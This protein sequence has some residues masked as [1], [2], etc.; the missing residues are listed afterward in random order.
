MAGM[1]NSKEVV[2]EAARFLRDEKASE[3]CVIDISKQS[4]FADFFVVATVNSFGAL[5]GLIKNLDGKLAELGVK[6]RGAKK[7]INEDDCW[8]LLDCADFIVHLMT[9][10]AREFYA[11]EK[12]WF[13]S[14][15]LDLD[16]GEAL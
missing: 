7:T 14:P 9:Q 2:L 8:I 6:A 5:R 12:L 4:G 10:Q 15:K 16:S 13:E 3:V 1:L 11:L